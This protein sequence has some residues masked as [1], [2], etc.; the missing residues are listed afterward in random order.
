MVQ[1]EAPLQQIMG[2]TIF[3]LAVVGEVIQTGPDNQV[4]HLV[5]ERLVFL[6][7]AVVNLV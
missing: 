2:L 1:M 7:V 5:E 3:F 6:L 4:V